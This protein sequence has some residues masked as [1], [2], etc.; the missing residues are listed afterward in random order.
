MKVG[1]SVSKAIDDWLAGDSESAMLHACNAVDGTARKKPYGNSGNAARFCRLIRE[2]TEIFGKFG[3]PG[4]N[5]DTT[6]FPISLANK[7]MVALD[8]AEILYKVH[9]CTH[10][11][12]DEL[13][14]GF[15][16]YPDAAGPEPITTMQWSGGKL[17]LSDSILFAMIGVAVVAPENVGQQTT[18]GHYLTFNR[19][20]PM[21]INEWWGRRDDMLAVVRTVEMPSVHLDFS[22]I[23]KTDSQASATSPTP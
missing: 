4:I 9:R 7:S 16:L 20:A 17:R 21:L 11:H 13:E 12:G 5:L 10:G 22:N 8:I 18:D 14:D 23:L 19:G 6:R 1:K 15:E 2:E 3:M